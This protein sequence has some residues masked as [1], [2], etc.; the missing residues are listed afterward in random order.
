MNSVIEQGKNIIFSGSQ[1]SYANK[2]EAK[3]KS[4]NYRSYNFLWYNKMDTFGK[5]QQRKYV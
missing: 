2:K 3:C 1:L 5:Y 4:P